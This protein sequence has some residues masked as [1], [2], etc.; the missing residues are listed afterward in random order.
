MPDVT[1]ATSSG[2]P[3]RPARLQGLSVIYIYPM[4]GADDSL[5]PDGWD[6]IPGARGCSPQSCS[7]RDHQAELQRFGARVYGLSTQSAGYLN[8]EVKRLHLPFD[9]V[10][11]EKLLLAKKLNVPTLDVEIAGRHVYKRV[12]LICRNDVIEYVFY[13]V[14]PPDQSAAQVLDWL[15]RNHR[16]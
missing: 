11:D 6:M 2:R 4:S 5:L 16:K 1:L 8:E 13:P 7:F 12:T 9:L 10:S 3:M 14:F 15:E